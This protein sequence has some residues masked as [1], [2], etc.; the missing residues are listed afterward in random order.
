MHGAWCWEPLVE[1]L[2]RAGAAAYALDLPGSG[3]RAAEAAAVTIADCA[4]AVAGLLAERDLQRVIL[5][6]HSM[7]G[8]TIPKAYELA[9]ERIAHLVYLSAVAVADGESILDTQPPGRAEMYQRL[10]AEHGGVA[11]SIP[12]DTAWEL[13]MNDLPRD[14]PRV[15]WALERVTPQPM[16]TFT[17]KVEMA[18]FYAL[19]APRTYVWCSRDQAVTWPRMARAM[20]T[21]GSGTRYVEIEA[22]HSVMLT[23]PRLL[24]DT[25]LEI[26]SRVRAV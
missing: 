17:E 4:R 3:S 19:Q 18:R 24:A 12:P 7:G 13:W 14:D 22:D 15:Q 23:N 1:E 8:L 9:P 10:A 26:R 5:V 16:S 25:L 21:L 6:G 2:R 11:F 20:A